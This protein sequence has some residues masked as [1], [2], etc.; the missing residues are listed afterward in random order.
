M[1]RAES[2]NLKNDYERACGWYGHSTRAKWRSSP[3]A[4]ISMLKSC[5]TPPTLSE[6]RFCDK[7]AKG[8]SQPKRFPPKMALCS[9]RHLFRLPSSPS[10]LLLLDSQWAHLGNYNL[11]LAEAQYSIPKC[12]SG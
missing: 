11:S 9:R 4:R 1:G 7:F 2:L 10:L 3:S 5:L 8:D 12:R 6:R